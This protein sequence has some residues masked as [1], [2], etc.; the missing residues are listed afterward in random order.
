MLT[1]ITIV[2]VILAVELLVFAGLACR[3]AGRRID[4]ILAE[5]LGSRPPARTGDRPV[6]RADEAPI[7]HLMAGPGAA[8]RNVG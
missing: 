5:E 1:M 4:R 2:A 8:S 6:V 3:R 7:P